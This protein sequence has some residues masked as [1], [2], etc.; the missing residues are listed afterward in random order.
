MRTEQ[1]T[2]YILVR[3]DDDIDDGKQFKKRPPLK[4][5]ARLIVHFIAIMDYYL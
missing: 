1:C 5:Q 4:D 2:Q 3:L